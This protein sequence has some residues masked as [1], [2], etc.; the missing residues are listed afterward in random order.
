MKKFIIRFILFLVVI[1]IVYLLFMLVPNM[2]VKENNIGIVEDLRSNNI[3]KI[4]YGKNNLILESVM[5][6]WFSIYKMPVKRSKIFDIGIPIPPIDKMKDHQYSVRMTIQGVYEILPEKF[7]DISSLKDNGRHLNRVIHVIINAMMFKELDMYFTPSYRGFALHKNRDTIISNVRDNLR[8]RLQKIGLNLIS[9]DIAGKVVIPDNATYKEGVRHFRDI[10]RID[11]N[12]EKEL[13][14]LKKVLEQKR[15]QNKELYK[16][17]SQLSGII[18]THPYIL[19]YMYINKL[20]DNVK[21]IVTSDKS[22]IPLDL[23]RFPKS[24]KND[25]KQ[26][27]DNLR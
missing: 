16:K 5:P 2:S 7:Y 13:R 23:D 24:K 14:K 11:K 8:E 3:V 4:F 21:V 17:L 6:W 10:R 1:L 25:K 12:S 26:E 18:K 22:G 19:K 27:I 15:L 20:A 9:F